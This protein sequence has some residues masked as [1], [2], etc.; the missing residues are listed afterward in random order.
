MKENS[1]S[2][3]LI[4]G[5]SSGIGLALAH[6][7]AARNYNLLLVSN[8]VEALDECKSTLE[9]KYGIACNTFN[10]DMI[11]KDS[12]L[13]IFEFAQT[14]APDI[15]ILVNNA[16]MLV[17]SE[18]VETPLVKLEAILQLHIQ[19][20][21]ALCKL[22]GEKMKANRKGHILNVSSISAVMPYPGISLYGPSKTYMRYFS[23]ALRSEMKLYNVNVTC[24]IPGAT[25]TGLYDPNRVNLTLAKQLGVMQTADVVAKKGI[26]AM[27]KNKAECIPGWLNKLTVASLPWIP[28][29]VI[30]MINRHSTILQKGNKALG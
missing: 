21:S 19:T 12:A 27:F 30:E 4:T 6:E 23:R 1:N 3:V 7:Y 11:A 14:H 18:V 10:V 9:S 13:R 22:F 26:D 15:E 28:S 24:L 2:F 29:F 8:Q 16:G 5:G 25:E 20:P 17:F